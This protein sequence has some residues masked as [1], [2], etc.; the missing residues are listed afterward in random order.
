MATTGERRAGPQPPLSPRPRACPQSPV[1]LTFT[2]SISSGMFTMAWVSQLSRLLAKFRIAWVKAPTGGGRGRSGPWRVG[3]GGHGRG[4][5][6]ALTGDGPQHVRDEDLHQALVQHV[7]TVL[8]PLQHWLELGQEHQAG[9]G[10][11]LLSLVMPVDSRPMP[12]VRLTRA[13][14][15]PGADGD[16]ILARRAQAPTRRR[17]GMASR[18]LL[19]QALGVRPIHKPWSGGQKVVCT[20]QTAG[21]RQM[22]P[23]HMMSEVW[24]PQPWVLTLPVPHPFFPSSPLPPRDSHSQR[25]RLV[26]LAKVVPPEGF[27]QRLHQGELQ[28]HH[29]V[30]DGLLGRLDAQ[31][32]GGGRGGSMAFPRPC[33][34][35][36]LP[37]LTVFPV[38]DL[39]GLDIPRPNALG[40]HFALEVKL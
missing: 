19:A 25:R 22:P 26:G 18:G 4:G 12:E 24:L 36:Q 39:E 38:Q 7:V 20:P 6:P 16:L 23:F 33:P 34:L 17:E 40:E 13:P 28:V 29:D 9:L 31:G 35:T 32:H 15:P 14:M 8:G 30:D 5:C 27:P 3:T 21:V 11:P 37:Y 2:R 1:S 10:Q